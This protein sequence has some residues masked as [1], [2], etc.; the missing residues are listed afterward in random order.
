MK[1][2]T[3]DSLLV[4]AYCAIVAIF[5]VGV[6][7]IFWPPTSAQQTLADTGILK[8]LGMALSRECTLQFAPTIRC[9]GSLAE[10]DE[11]VCPQGT[12]P[13]RERVSKFRCGEYGWARYVLEDLQ[14]ERQQRSK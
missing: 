11:L 3:T 5:G 7:T 1:E 2:R 13:D 8:Q 9:K 6:A 12:G 10:Y 14:S 4:V